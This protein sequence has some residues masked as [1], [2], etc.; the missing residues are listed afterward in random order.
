MIFK[1]RVNQLKDDISR[2]IH[3]QS[4]DRIKGVESAIREGAIN[5]LNEINPPETKRH[6]V[7]DN[8]IDLGGG[9][10]SSEVPY[11]VKQDRIIALEPADFN[12]SWS[13]YKPNYVSYTDFRKNKDRN[14]FSITV[15]DGVKSILYYKS[16]PTDDYELVY[17]SDCIFVK[18]DDGRLIYKIEPINDDDWVALEPSTYNILL[19]EILRQLAQQTQGSDAGF[20]VAFFEGELFGTKSKQGLYRQYKSRYHSE[21]TR[22]KT[23]YY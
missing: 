14:T 18:D 19:Y 23:R 10:F 21:A 8:T 1:F 11:D 13:G 6:F 12:K 5:L 22:K 9:F 17:Y 20:D 3:S 2:K 4:L 16:E 7:L 15:S